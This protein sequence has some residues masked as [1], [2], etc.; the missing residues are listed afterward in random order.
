MAIERLFI[1]IVVTAC[2]LS[3]STTCAFLREQVRQSFR[4]RTRSLRN[5]VAETK[6]I[7]RK[8]RKDTQLRSSSPST[9]PFPKEEMRNIEFKL[10]PSISS[11]PSES[12]DSC[13]AV[14]GSSSPFVEHAWLRCL[15]ESGCVS[16]Q[17]GWVPQH[18]SILIDG[19]IRGYVPMYMKGHSQGEFIVDTAWAK[20]AYYNGIKYYPK[21]LVGI[22]FTPATGSRILFH[23]SVYEMYSRNDVANTRVLVGSYLKQV[24]HA[25]KISSVHFNFLTLDEAT[26]LAGDLPQSKSQDK[27]ENSLTE[28]VKSRLDQ[29]GFQDN[30]NYLRRTSLQYHWSNSN[31]NNDNKPYQSFEEYLGCF[32]SKRRITIRRERAKVL[33]DE[34]IRID[35]V[36]GKDI[37]QYDGLVERM[38]EIY[39]STI[40][41]LFLGRQ[42]LNLEFFQMLA[43]TDMVKNLCFMCARSK[44]SGEQLKPE[45]V[46][47]GTF[48]I[49]KD[50]VFYGRY[51][52]CL[53]EKEAKNLHFETCYWSSIDYCIRH[54]LER[55][56]PGAGGGDYKWSRGFDAALIHST[57]Y[58]SNPNLR[59]AVSQ[60]L[61]YETERNVE[62]TKDL[63]TRSVF[64]N[65]KDS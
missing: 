24:A 57:H 21:I 26:D 41:K 37:L 32:K 54:G 35:A 65:S 61:D 8:G 58:I 3:S 53:P 51:W 22:P 34:N 59:Q 44:S 19:E 4:R 46:F 36:I 49:I 25:N 28:Q 11:I 15:E 13:L 29:L 60:Y 16:A 17:T 56:E 30:D 64:N 23:P 55:M 52:G 50:G 18:I 45:D 20:A 5:P 42:Y 10:H 2:L 47:A 27:L 40:D 9:S 33:H 62:A 48:N 12:W 1:V 14:D 38:F 6:N 63:L 31:V 39:L 43:K 7:N